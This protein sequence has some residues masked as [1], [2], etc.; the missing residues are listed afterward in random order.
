MRR[1]RGS[2]MFSL[3]CKFGRV[4]GYLVLV[5]GGQPVIRY[6]GVPFAVPPVDKHR[7]YPSQTAEPLGRPDNG[8]SKRRI[9][10]VDRD[11]P[12]PQD[13][14]LVPSWLAASTRETSEDC[15]YMNLWTPDK[16][17]L[18]NGQECGTRAVIVFFHGGDLRHTGNKAYDGGLL[19]SKANAVVAI[20]NYR[21]GLL[22]SSI[23]N[24]SESVELGLGDQIT[25]VRWLKENVGLFGGNASR[26][27]LA[28]HGAGAASV[29]HWM[30]S[31]HRDV[32]DVER[33]VLI[34]GSP[35]TRYM[36]DTDVI[37]TNIRILARRVQCESYGEVAS[38]DEALSCLR[39]LPSALLVPRLTGLNGRVIDPSRS[40]DDVFAAPQEK[41]LSSRALLLGSVPDEGFH[42]VSRMASL[43]NVPSEWM[44]RWLASQGINDAS[45]FLHD[46]QRELGAV[47]STV[48]WNAAYADVRYRCPMRR[49]AERMASSGVAVYRFVFDARP[50]FENPG[51][52]GEADHYAAVR[53]S[54]TDL[55]RVRTTKADVAARDRLVDLL[56]SFLN[57]G[58]LPKTLNGEEWAVYN[59]STKAA[60]VITGDGLQGVTLNQDPCRHEISHE[61][62]EYVS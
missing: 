51:L 20:P 42:F 28:G 21:L 39:K 3:T 37:T 56:N 62:Q 9:N 54:L 55:S 18:F 33:F 32:A 22:G 59:K 14:A 45:A 34:S 8:S 25:A 19:A 10:F 41:P 60:V 17:C 15:L 24:E 52:G 2:Y 7:F 27:T 49:F 35:Y 5:P 26:L 53:L 23:V 61:S 11:R 29:G 13:G 4:D 6:I 12:C 43:D 48:V 58:P 57:T 38:T 47:N 44:L 36:K 46:Y 16:E 30:L 31:T 50:S 1:R 40:M